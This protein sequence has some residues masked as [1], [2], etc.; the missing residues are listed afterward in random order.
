MSQRP[1][2]EDLAKA[3]KVSSATVDRVLNK[4]LR[5]RE[6]TAQRV[7]LAAEDIGYHAAGLLKQRVLESKERKTIVVLLQQEGDVF[8]NTLGQAIDDA[9]HELA[10]VH[11]NIKTQ[12]MENVSASCISHYLDIYGELADAIVIVALDHPEV[13]QRLEKLSLAGK[14]IITL[15][16]D[17]SAPSRC[18]HIGV[19]NHKNGRTAGWAISRLAK[20]PGKVG[21]LLGSHDLRNQQLAE[22][23]FIRY[24]QQHKQ[25]FTVLQT[26]LD[27]DDDTLAAKAT[28]QLLN[29]HPDLV[30][31]Y[32]AGGGVT[33]IV[34][35]LRVTPRHKD[36]VVVCNEIMPSTAAAL[37]EGIIDMVINSPV[38]SLSDE[39]FKLLNQAFN[40]KGKS[41]FKTLQIAANIYVAENI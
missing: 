6:A 35:A 12:Y 5:V 2:I 4:R 21:I 10:N 34:E 16:S 39:V 8:Y 7:L 32:S 40:N 22:A 37:R 31:L 20:R 13:N 19:N 27:L 17:A 11:Y 38:A 41:E 28:T 33:G 23:S 26:Q 9:S 24:L 15:M 29:N 14:H 1:T 25:R 18:G 3:A 30:G 36:I